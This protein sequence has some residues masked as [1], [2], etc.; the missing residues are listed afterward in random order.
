MAC[1]F[2][3]YLLG[4]NMYKAWRVQ[5]KKKKRKCLDWSIWNIPDKNTACLWSSFKKNSYTIDI[6][7]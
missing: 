2:A 6:V 4:I 1:K 3:Y 7:V 5:F